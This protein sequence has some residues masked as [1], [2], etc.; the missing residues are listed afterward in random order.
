MSI[1]NEPLVDEDTIRPFFISESMEKGGNSMLARQV[2]VAP[3]SLVA[4]FLLVSSSN[5]NS[6]MQLLVL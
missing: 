6:K 5:I 2:I 3:S 1:C 4:A